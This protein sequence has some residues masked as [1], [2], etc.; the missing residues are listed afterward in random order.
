[1]AEIDPDQVH[2]LRAAIEAAAG[3]V[4]VHCG[5]GQRAC[6]LGLLATDPRPG[7]ELI[8]RAEQAG[9]PVTDERLRAFVRS[10]SD[11]IGWDLL[12]AI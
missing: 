9:F 4:Y 2:R 8:A 3:P 1:M 5:A 7:D 11:R 12:Q 10:R 6:S